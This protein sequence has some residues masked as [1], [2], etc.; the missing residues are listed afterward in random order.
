MKFEV[1]SVE[2]KRALGVV[3]KGISNKPHLPILSGL[4]IRVKNNVT[5]LTATDLEIS[6][7]M[8]I[9]ATVKEEGEVVVPARLFYD[10]VSTLEEGRINIEVSELKMKILAKGV[11]TEILCQSADDYPVIPT[12]NTKGI[13]INSSEFRKKIDKVIMSSAK[14]DTR[15]IL[16]GILFKIT[17]KDITFVATDGFRLSVNV[18][19][20]KANGESTEEKVIIPSRSLGELLKVIS[21]LTAESF[22]VEIDKHSKQVIF[23]FSGMEMSSRILDGEFPPYQ[24]IIPNTYTT[25]ISLDKQSLVSAVKRASLFARESANVIRVKVEDKLL[26]SAENSQIGSNVTEIEGKIEG[27]KINVAFN[28]KYLL[29]FLPVVESDFVEWETEGELKPSVFRDSKDEK[30]LQVVMPIRTQ[31]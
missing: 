14:D 13:T 17:G 25:K 26:V 16:T 3:F 24:Q 21:E 4:L 23:V 8:E 1:S 15:P 11:D 22:R 20:L 9:E 28:A 6:F 31:S 2:L 12:S 29:D 30:W 7:W 27:E 19:E 10:L 5:S 18:M